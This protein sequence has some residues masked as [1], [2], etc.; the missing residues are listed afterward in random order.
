MIVRPNGPTQLLITQ[1]D[2][3]ALAARIMRAWR[4]DGLPALGRRAE[5]L[6]AV[7][8]HDNGWQEVDA[9]P[10]V[11]RDTGKVLDFMTAPDAVRRG[12][13][14]RGVGRLAGTPYAAA[15]VAQ[16]AL[17]IYRRYRDEDAWAPFFAEM[18]A[19]REHHLSAAGLRSHDELRR[20]YLFVRVA[21]LASLT[22]CNGWTETQ[23]DDSGSGYAVHLDETSLL[24]GPDPFD[25][26]E[27]PLEIPAR[28]L[29][30]APFASHA[31]ALRAFAQAAPV[32]LQGVA[33]GT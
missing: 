23:T 27:V 2:H 33:R 4:R 15:L 19:A 3:A 14:P 13:W 22:F 17:H 11:D 7:E 24:I 25:G 10:V 8:E 31:E 26:H 5:I 29:S 1:P 16:H 12:V 32:R 30:G 18:E 28:E 6:I 20:D 21:D 9:A